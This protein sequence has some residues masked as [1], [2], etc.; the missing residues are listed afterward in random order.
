MR[1]PLAALRA[2]LATQ[3]SVV[4]DKVSSGGCGRGGGVHAA[5]VRGEVEHRRGRAPSSEAVRRRREEDLDSAIARAGGEGRGARRLMTLRAI[6]APQGKR[7][8]LQAVHSLAGPDRH[9]CT[10]SERAEVLGEH[11]GQVFCGRAD[12]PRATEELL[13]HEVPF[14]GVEPLRASVVGRFMGCPRPDVGFRSGPWRCLLLGVE[15][16]WEEWQ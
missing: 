5:R 11:W 14:E 9:A 10:R 12:D 7:R 4:R 16:R 8:A 2:R 15:G 6:W 1:S 3:G 13:R